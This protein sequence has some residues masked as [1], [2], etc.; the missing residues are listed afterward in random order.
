MS[1]CVLQKTEAQKKAMIIRKQ[2]D[3]K[4]SKSQQFCILH[5]RSYNYFF[6]WTSSEC[7][8]DDNSLGHRG[9]QHPDIQ[10]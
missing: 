6:K 5:A 4:A 7:A 8:D 3:K 2:N 9:C 1:T 10:L